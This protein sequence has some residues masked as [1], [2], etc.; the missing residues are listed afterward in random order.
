MS[1]YMQALP[2]FLGSLVVTG[3]WLGRALLHA[4][5]FYYASLVVMG[6]ATLMVMIPIDKSIA[7]HGKKT[8]VLAAYTYRNAAGMFAELVAFLALAFLVDVFRIG[9][10]FAAAAMFFIAL[11]ATVARPRISGNFGA[12]T[13]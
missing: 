7:S 8:D 1:N 10:V 5:S 3:L 9:F 2:I 13:S 4:T 6:F 12:K 11:V